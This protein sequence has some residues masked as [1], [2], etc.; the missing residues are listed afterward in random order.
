[1]QHQHLSGENNSYPTVDHVHNWSGFNHPQ[2]KNK[3][4]K[5][6]TILNEKWAATVLFSLLCNWNFQLVFVVSVASCYLII[7]T[8]LWNSSL[9]TKE[10]SY[11]AALQGETTGRG[12]HLKE[13]KLYQNRILRHSSKDL[14]FNRKKQILARGTEL[15]T[16]ITNGTLSLSLSLSLV[17]LCI[18]SSWSLSS[19][20][21]SSSSRPYFIYWGQLCQFLF[22][23]F[24][25]YLQPCFQ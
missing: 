25:T 21:S 15:P 24:N 9:A 7:S 10:S 14:D 13:T 23:T 12:R 16:C 4:K 1:M 8:L 3:K 20:S 5:K 22:F 2:W 18:A 6:K 11:G 17:W 19:S